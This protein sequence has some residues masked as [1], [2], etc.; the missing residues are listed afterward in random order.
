MNTPT[1][2]DESPSE[3]HEVVR[4]AG[5]YDSLFGLGPVDPDTQ[6]V[7]NE[8]SSKKAQH[9]DKDV[10]LESSKLLGKL[11]HERV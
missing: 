11:G 8:P 10:M 9:Y 1:E 3:G 5:L 2:P 7:I 6:I 4:M